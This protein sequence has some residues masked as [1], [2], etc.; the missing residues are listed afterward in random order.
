ME[1]PS[2][3]WKLLIIWKLYNWAPYS[4]TASSKQVKKFKACNSIST[5]GYPKRLAHQSASLG[6]SLWNVVSAS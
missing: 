4:L 2:S 1:L 3:V 6:A 5:K